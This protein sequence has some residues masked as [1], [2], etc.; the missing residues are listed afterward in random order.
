MKEEV[1]STSP[2]DGGPLQ[3]VATEA[4]DAMQEFGE[5]G[6]FDD[7]VDVNEMIS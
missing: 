4:H 6:C 5:I 1:L 3:Y 7:Q 2:P